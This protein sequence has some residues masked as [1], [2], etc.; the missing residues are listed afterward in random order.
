MG[1]IKVNHAVKDK[2]GPGQ[3]QDQVLSNVSQDLPSVKE[4][5]AR[6]LTIR[7]ADEQVGYNI[8]GREVEVQEERLEIH[9]KHQVGELSRGLKLRE[10]MQ[11]IRVFEKL[12][13]EEPGVLRNAQDLRP[14]LIQIKMHEVHK[15]S[16]DNLINVLINLPEKRGIL[17]ENV[18]IAQEIQVDAVQSKK[19][20]QKEMDQAERERAGSGVQRGITRK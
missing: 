13:E 3:I 14:M 15:L 19:R 12:D 10:K 7:N 18:S 8:V 5:T 11:E 9:R 20:Q 17:Q 16:M 2:G 4:I 6:E 1:S